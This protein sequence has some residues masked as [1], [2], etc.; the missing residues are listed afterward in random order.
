MC[1]DTNH[2]RRLYCAM[3]LFPFQAV[4][5]GHKRLRGGQSTEVLGTT[6]PTSAAVFEYLKAVDSLATAAKSHYE[7][8]CCARFCKLARGRPSYNGGFAWNA[9]N[10]AE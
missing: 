10:D 7:A 6:F 9:D 5:R 8:M 2:S 3:G 4:G 1:S